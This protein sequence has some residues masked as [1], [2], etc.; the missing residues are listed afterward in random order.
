MTPLAVR[1]TQKLNLPQH[2]RELSQLVG[3][4][5]EVE[6]LL[7]LAATAAMRAQGMTVQRQPS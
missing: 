6:E 1:L 4:K 5:V 3:R 7:S 2:L